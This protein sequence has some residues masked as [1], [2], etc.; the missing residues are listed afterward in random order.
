MK[1]EVHNRCSD[2]DSYRAARV[3]SLFNAESGANFDL[4]ADLPIDDNDW[5][6]GVIVGP[7]GSGKTSMGRTMFGENAFYNPD[8]WAHDKPIIDSI[9][10]DG[11]FNEITGALAAVGLGTVPTWLRPFPVLSNGEK[12]RA[13]LARLICEHPARVVVDE[14]TS[15]VDRQIAKFGALAFQ[16]AWRRTGGRVVLLSCHYDIIDWVEPD[17]IFDTASGKYSGRSLWRRP[18]FEL[19]I[20]KTDGSYWRMFEPHHYLKLPR[21]VAAEYFVGTVDGEPVCH[22]AVAPRLEIGGVRACRMVVMPEW[23][24]AGIGVRFLNSICQW[25]V[26]GNS[27]YG[28]RPKAVYFH[29]SHPGLVAALRRDKKWVQVSAS[30]YGADKASQ[31][32]REAS[33][34]TSSVPGAGGHFRA[35]Q[36]F[37]YV[38]EGQTA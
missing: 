5:K 13:N 17:W 3:K 6:I 11:D 28:T 30:L 10:P 34:K 16:K 25:Y 20:W 12:F 31:K 2:F 7:S 21:M 37:K 36:G 33:G 38:G 14:F 15:V 19:Q 1:I 24:G 32:K 35:V 22:L 29:T 8:D 18:K 23:Q 4:V 26:D 9:A 27:K